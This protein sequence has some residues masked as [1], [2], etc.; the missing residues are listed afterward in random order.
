MYE[1]QSSDEFRVC[2]R[3]LDITESSL[4]LPLSELSESSSRRLVSD[5][6]LRSGG[7]GDLLNKSHDVIAASKLQN[8]THANR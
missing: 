2:H 4:V 5:S 6:S 1:G 3:S 7:S 8:L